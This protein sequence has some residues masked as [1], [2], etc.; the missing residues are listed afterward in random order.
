MSTEAATQSVLNETGLSHPRWKTEAI[1]FTVLTVAV[2]ICWIPR[3]RGPIDL[4]WDGAVYYVLGTSLAE[5]HGYRL[6]NEPGNIEANQYPPMLPAIIAAHQLI[7][8]TNDPIIV[9]RW[10]RITYFLFFNLYVF[11]IYLVAVGYLPSKYA[12]LATVIC[13]FGLFTYFMSDL[14]FPEIPFALATTLFVLFNR[15]S[16]KRTDAVF[17]GLFAVVA[18]ALR[19]AGIALLAAWV[20]ESV[21]KKDLRRAMFRSVV[22]GIAVFS[23]LLY[24]SAVESGKA[25]KIPRMNISAPTISGTTSAMRETSLS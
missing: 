18:Y 21:I 6:L 20:G 23:W 4:R 13:V 24:I 19:T 15:N 25:T 22:S 9:G 8:G 17:A 2:L 16:G 10:L 12:L 11:T 14:S 7:L 1:H 5:G 3:L